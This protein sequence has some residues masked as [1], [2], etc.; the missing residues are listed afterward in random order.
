MPASL[1]LPQELR[2]GNGM[3]E[4]KVVLVNCARTFKLNFV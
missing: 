4:L 2:P 3:D 1:A